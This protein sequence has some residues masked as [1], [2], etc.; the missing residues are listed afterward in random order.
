MRKQIV[1]NK[2]GLRKMQK[3]ARSKGAKTPLLH[4]GFCNKTFANQFVFG[5]LPIKLIPPK[6]SKEFKKICPTFQIPT[7]I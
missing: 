5:I 1:K 4:A 3:P 6:F 7:H 2:I